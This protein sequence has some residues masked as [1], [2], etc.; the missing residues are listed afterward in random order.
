MTTK[1]FKKLNN[2]HT[3]YV[4]ADDIGQAVGLNHTSVNQVIRRHKRELENVSRE[5]LNY[6]RD[7]KRIKTY[8]LN[9]PQAILL[10][11]FMRSNATVKEFST[12]LVKHTYPVNE[13]VENEETKRINKLLRN[14]I[15]TNNQEQNY[16]RYFD[17]S[18]RLAFGRS[19]KKLRE[20]LNLPDSKVIANFLNDDAVERVNQSRL[21]IIKELNNGGNF[22]TIAV[23][24]LTK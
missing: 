16:K 2:N 9:Q 11:V 12:D 19:A 13:P 22:D 1:L 20:S 4:K 3:S 8:L 10:T 23:K 5:R 14:A 21:D 24:L 15:K 17:L 6:R 18:Y 7:S